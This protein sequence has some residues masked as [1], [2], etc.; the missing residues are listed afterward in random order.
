MV[1]AFLNW[2]IRAQEVGE[3]RRQTMRLLPQCQ[4]SC[5]L[6]ALNPVAAVGDDTDSP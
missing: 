2:G 5:K 6:G 1:H 3:V 4:E